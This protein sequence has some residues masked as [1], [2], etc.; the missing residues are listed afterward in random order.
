[1]WDFAEN[2][3]EIMTIP[4]GVG[5]NERNPG[6]AVRNGRDLPE[7][8]RLLLP[9]LY[10]TLRQIYVQIQFIIWA[11]TFCNLN[12]YILKLEHVQWLRFA[13]DLLP[14]L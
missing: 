6:F 7:S 11:N 13:R 4:T 10:L 8:C 2:N 5:V 1:M 12:K 14:S 9:P 3:L